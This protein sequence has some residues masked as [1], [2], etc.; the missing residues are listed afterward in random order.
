MDLLMEIAE[1]IQRWTQ[2]R[3]AA[4]EALHTVQAGALLETVPEAA[5]QGRTFSLRAERLS[6]LRVAA[7]M[8]RFTLDSYQPECDLLE[9]T[10][11]NWRGEIDAFQPDLLMIESAWQGKDN[12]WYRKIANGSKEYF[13]MTA[14]CREKN[15]PIVFW[16][17]EDP[18]YTD[19]FMPAAAM[20]D[21]VFTTDIDC[22]KKYQRALGHNRVYHLHFAAQPKIHN[23]IEKYPRQ[24]KF[25]FAGAYYH[26]YPQ[27]AKVFDAFSEVFL[28]GKGLDIYDRNFGHARPE[29]A[30]PRQYAPYILGTLDPSE[31]DRAYKGYVYGVNMNSVNQSQSMFARRVF[32]M[33]ASNTVTVG[34]YARGQKN[35]FGDLNICTDDPETL[36]KMLERYCKDEQTARKYRLL[37]LRK[38]LSEHLYEDR[39]DYI[40]QKVFGKSLKRP[41]PKITVFA[42][43]RTRQ[44]QKR[45]IA[46]YEAQTYPSKAMVLFGEGGETLRDE[47][48][49]VLPPEKLSGPVSGYAAQGFT[50][51]FRPED[52]YGPNYLLD[53][54]LTLRYGSYAAIGKS[55]WYAGE[56]EQAVLRSGERYE[57]ARALA[58]CRSIA[59]LS[60]SGPMGVEDYLN[61]VF[62]DLDGLFSAD[63][64]NYCADWARAR[65]PQAEDLY[66]ADQGIPL[67]RIEAIAE[68]TDASGEAAGNCKELDKKLLSGIKVSGNLPVSFAQSETD[69]EI[70]SQMEAGVHNNFYISKVLS[71]SEYGDGTKLHVI[72]QGNGDLDVMGIVILLDANRSRLKVISARMNRLQS[73]DV[74]A[75]AV[76]IQLGLRVSGPGRYLLRRVAFGEDCMETSGA[77]VSRSEVLVLTNQ[78]PSFQDLYR[79]AFVHK[80][81]TAYRDRGRLVD[82]MRMNIYAKDGYREFEGINVVEGQARKL[83][84]ILDGGT[85]RTVCVHFLDEQMWSVLKYHLKELRL[86]VWLHG[87]EIQPW[88]RREYN[89]TTEKELE[90]GKAASEVRQAF[91][92][93]VFETAS[94]EQNIHF[95]FVSQYFAD[96]VMEDNHISLRP[97][98]YSVIHNCID[99]ELFHYIP[100]DKEQRKKL[101]SIK[102]FYSKTYAN[103]IT[104][105]AIVILSREP[106]FRELEFTLYGRGE[107]FAI[108]TADIRKF[109][110]VHLYEQFLTHEQIAEQHK[111]HGI[112]IATTRSDTQGVSRDEAMS[113]GL[114]PVA[115]NVTAIPE[116][117]DENCGILVPG[118]DPQAVAD[119]IKRLYYD[120][121]LFLRLSEGAAKRVRGQS[122]SEN[123]IDKELRLIVP[124]Q[125][126]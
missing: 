120:P 88:W 5:P 2:A 9:V 23:P 28:R 16:N 47:T 117:V 89:F 95:I 32:E 70:A 29:H 83:A 27:R 124:E 3:G 110:N 99:T 85:I 125:P 7:V 8:D 81:V 100:K 97:E 103:D 4:V 36:E 126:C 109:K 121:E 80:R 118:E 93:E 60:L 82:V 84:E 71:A 22:I 76:S 104:S 91:W 77:F 61:A 78:Y 63:E 122:S 102:S 50:A 94:R 1:R 44:E 62:A 34:N 114:V 38:V 40:V 41:L 116:F 111:L 17:K 74:P 46:A 119:A 12:L 13:D 107:R 72:F 101:L 87:A 96:E 58:S 108:D 37:G 65:C 48:I 10:P 31:I 69:V 52:W 75:G 6:Q 14:Y 112:Y 26:R 24:D 43:A 92:K 49:Q 73:E 55:C 113:S 42:R 56:G 64:F 86:L 105:Q 90:E 45:L 66:V 15:I 20:A 51:V 39:L 53:L 98:Q 67:A 54:A 79:N 19:T 11:E 57:P 21:V 123:T 59:A 35:Y 33:M 25:C 68:R 18:I 115:S 30:F 106:F